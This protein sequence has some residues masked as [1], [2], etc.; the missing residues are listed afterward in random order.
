MDS[1]N[2]GF[3]FVNSYLNLACLGKRYRIMIS[4]KKNNNIL[5]IDSLRSIILSKI[6]FIISFCINSENKYNLT[7]LAEY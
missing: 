2:H 3:P 4:V 5:K 1:C 7:K 6:F